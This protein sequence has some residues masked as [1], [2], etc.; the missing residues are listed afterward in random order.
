LTA[1][2]STYRL[3]LHAGFGFGDAAALAPYLADIGVTHLYSSPYLQAAP[4]STHGYDVVDPT[5]VND[6]LG[7]ADGHRRLCSAL[8][9]AGL[10]QVLDVVPNHMANGP[11]N[12]WWWD[13]LEDGRASP[14]ARWFDVDWDPPERKLKDRLLMAVLGDQY[15]RVLDAGEIHLAYD[16]GV[17]TVSYYEHTLPVAPRSLD[18]LLKM[19]SGACQSPSADELAFLAHTFGRLPDAT[20]TDRQSVHERHRDTQVLRAQLSRLCAEDQAAADAVAMVVDLHNQQ[21]DLLH[22]LLERQNW[23]LAWWRTASRELDYR[24]FFDVNTLVGLRMEDPRVFADT[25]RLVLSW[26]RSGVLDGVRIDHP[27]GL[28]RPLEYLQR[29]RAAAPEAWIVVEKILEPG[30]PL[31][32]SWPVQGTTGYD[33]LNLVAGVFVDPAAEGPLTELYGR[34]TG[35]RT[36]WDEV[37]H[38]AKH[39]VLDRVLAADVTRLT[40][41]LTRVVERHRR[42]RDTTRHDLHEAVREILAC[43]GV[44]RA[45]VPEDGPGD[46]AERVLLEEAVHDAGDRRPDLDRELL[47]F[48]A[49]VLGGA[50]NGAADADQERE[51][52]MRFQQLTGPVM[53][54]GVEDTAFYRYGRFVALNEVGGDPGRFGVVPKELHEE[55]RRLQRD[56]PFGMTTLS[57]HD[58][59]RSEDV[60]ARLS[61]LSEV[62]DRWA[63]LVGR[64]VADGPVDRG[65]QYA[66]LQA[67]VGAWPLPAERAATFAEK[68]V[69]EAKRATSWVDQDPDYEAAVRAWVWEWA[70]DGPRG[71]ELADLAAAVVGPGRVNAVAA[72]LVQLCM[73]GV[74]DTYQGSEVEDLS[75]VDPDNRR[76][77]DWDRRRRLLAWLATGPPPEEILARSDE[78]APKL[79]VVRQALRLRRRL[80]EPFGAGDGGAY[81]PLVAS[82]PAAAHVV[83]FTR[84]GRVACVVPRLTVRLA[85]AGGWAGTV[86][87]LGPGHWRDE[88]TGDDVDGGPVPVADLLARFPVALLVGAGA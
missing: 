83:G 11:E 34:V 48:L 81:E 29:L 80:P 17:F 51:A 71:G 67:L 2:L 49:E 69:R 52:C 20:S 74:P 7:G 66:L 24:R 8:G 53:A 26:L 42:N 77:V 72:K 27:D 59:K 64:V 73:P 57:T 61:V 62:P 16:E 36:E 23:R 15:G 54:K 6:E 41:G 22:V 47:A 18:D 76:P 70:A 87:T 21:P 68:A 82:G 85:A 44:Y 32:R 5:K 86:L 60:R 50:F 9:D 40:D 30:E 78:G 75:L 63:D 79:W 19:A 1:P 39:D 56:W 65:T 88:L 28:R 3:Q 10:G 14:W 84:G 46:R 58:T 31:R 35:E 25:H 55:C 12:R 37:A 38:E 45:Y 4:G 33:T 43:F 13:V